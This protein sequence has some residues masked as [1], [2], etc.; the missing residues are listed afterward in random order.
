M[1]FLLYVF[2]IEVEFLANVFLF[3]ELISSEIW[4]LLKI[5]IKYINLGYIGKRKEMCNTV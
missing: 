5:S 3:G 4:I 1:R 2:L